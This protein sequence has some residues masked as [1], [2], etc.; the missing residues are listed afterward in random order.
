[1]NQTAMVALANTVINYKGTSRK[2]CD[3]NKHIQQAKKGE[4]DKGHR[5]TLISSLRR[6]SFSIIHAAYR[7]VPWKKGS[8]NQS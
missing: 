8:L 7:T 4:R 1:M 2:L 3:G 6:G 5:N